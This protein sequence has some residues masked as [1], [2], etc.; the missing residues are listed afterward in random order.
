[1]TKFSWW[2]GQRNRISVVEGGGPY[3]APA[4]A[5]EPGWSEFF[6]AIAPVEDDHGNHAHVVVTEELTTWDE[7]MLRKFGRKLGLKVNVSR[8]SADW[9]A[10]RKG[11]TEHACRIEYVVNHL[12]RRGSDFR[13]S[14]IQ[15]PE[16]VRRANA[17]WARWR[18]AA[19]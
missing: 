16:W 15:M 2:R 10:N 5:T 8:N 9:L 19:A 6:I 12:R 18:R 11:V 17:T 4:D 1:M 7:Y 3:P 14:G 13:A